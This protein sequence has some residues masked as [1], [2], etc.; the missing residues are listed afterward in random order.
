MT[1]IV[2]EKKSSKHFYEIVTLI[3]GEIT[4]IGVEANT[5]TQA[6]SIAKKNGYTV[7]HV[8]MIG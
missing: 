4:S 7:R 5:S 8:N 1:D 3:D 2:I 6:A